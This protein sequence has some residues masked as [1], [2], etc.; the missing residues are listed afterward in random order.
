M[1]CSGVGGSYLID[2]QMGVKP[3]L[4]IWYST[5]L[6]SQIILI[7]SAF[8]LIPVQIRFGQLAEGF[9]GGKEKKWRF[10]SRI[11]SVGERNGGSFVAKNL[12]RGADNILDHINEH[13]YVP[14]YAF[15]NVK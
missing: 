6:S 14:R 7:L 12:V 3:T 2:L 9:C 1:Q 8:C 13:G 15:H 4:S 11:R 5:F 10:A